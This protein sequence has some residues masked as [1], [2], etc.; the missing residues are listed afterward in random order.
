MRIYQHVPFTPQ[1]WRGQAKEGQAP[2]VGDKPVPQGI[3]V[4]CTGKKS[5]TAIVDTGDVHV[6]MIGAAGVG[7]TAFWLYPCIEYACASGMSFMST[8]TKG[9]VMR[10]Y[11]TIAKNYYGY[12]VSVI[13]LRNPT[14]SNGNNLLYLVN[15]YMDLY[16]A[17]PDQLVYKAKSEKYAKII[18]KT[19][20]LS[21]SDASSFGANAYFYDSAEGLLTA[22]ILLVAEFCEPSKRHIVSV[23]KII[24]ELLAPAGKKGKNQFQQLMQLLPDDHKAK[25]FAG[26]ALNTAEQSMASVMSTAL[27][28]LN[29]FLDTELEQLLCFDTEIDAETFCNEKSAIFLIMPEESPHTFF[30]VSL[31]IQQLYREILSVADETGGKLKN[32]CVFLCDE[33]GT[34]PKIE[35]AEMMFSA[36]RSRRLQIVPVI[37]SFAQLERNYGK[38]SADIIID[39]VQLT[40][41]G[42]FAPNSSSAEILSKSLGNRTVLTGSVSR[43]RNDPSQSLQMTERPLM[44]PDELKALPKGSFIVMK[45]GFHPMQVKLRLFFE[46]GITFEEPY[47]V[48]EKG[49]RKVY[50]ADKEEIIDG[51]M[52]K[53]HADDYQTEEIPPVAMPADV[54]PAEQTAEQTAAETAGDTTSE[55]ADKTKKTKTSGAKNLKLEP[56]V[57]ADEKGGDANGEA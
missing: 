41:F 18:A 42:G 29:A 17:N 30:M 39:N 53:Y 13:D 10:N 9:D 46:W 24:Q 2:T 33:F 21:G 5:V 22:T 6:L 15:R 1:K 51:I 16:K 31:I 52:A 3:V 4:G 23:F 8:D 35:S 54:Q 19:I 12:N 55:K 40:L 32:R 25:W 43:G 57:S 34:L 7:K 49:N 14:R 56:T 20:I 38:E 48:E 44:T 28:R 26:A 37:Q 45:T 50:Y 47:T 36:A 11:G 27:S